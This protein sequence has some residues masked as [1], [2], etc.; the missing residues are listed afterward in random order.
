MR[1]ERRGNCSSGKSVGNERVPLFE[2]PT[3]AV[4]WWPLHVAT[5]WTL[6]RVETDGFRMIL[7]SECTRLV[8]DDTVD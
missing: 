8:D 5:N 2:I 3:I 7:C 4:A 6:P 1:K